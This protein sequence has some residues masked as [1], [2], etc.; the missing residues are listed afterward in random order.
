[1]PSLFCVDEHCR[2]FHETP[3]FRGFFAV[4]EIVMFIAAIVGVAITAF[5]SWE[6][7]R[8]P[9]D[10]QAVEVEEQQRLVPHEIE[11]GETVRRRGTRVPSEARTVP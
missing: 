5:D 9:L 8:R 1:M 4:V 10:L 11:M 3:E 6:R 2:S 7:R